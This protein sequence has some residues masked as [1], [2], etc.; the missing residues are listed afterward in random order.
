MIAKALGVNLPVTGGFI[1]PAPPPTDYK[2]KYEANFTREKAKLDKLDPAV[3]SRA[4][5]LLGKGWDAGYDLTITQG[6]RSFA[7]QDKLY[8]QGRTTPGQIVTNARGGQS[9]HNFGLAFDVFDKN[10]KN[11][12]AV[13]WKGIGKLGEDAGL[14]WG[15]TWAKFPDRPHFQYLGGLSLSQVQKGERPSK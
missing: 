10:Q 4:E 13:D 1:A 5:T 2:K 6:F 14:E 11:W 8:A 9:F 12:D 7:E 3:R 15:G